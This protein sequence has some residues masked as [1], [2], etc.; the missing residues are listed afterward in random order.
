MGSEARKIL[1]SAMALSPNERAELA[2]ELIAS[3]DRE[4]EPGAEA[5]WSAEITRR[6]ERVLSGESQGVPWETVQQDVRAAIGR[7]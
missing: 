7:K 6:A 3:L 4:A 2:R 1:E 5:A